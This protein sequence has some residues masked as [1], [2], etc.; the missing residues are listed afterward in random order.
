MNLAFFA[1]EKQPK[2]A[3]VVDDDP[4]ILAVYE[5]ALADLGFT[6]VLVSNAC[7]AL[8]RVSDIAPEIVILDQCMPEMTG[9]ELART[10]RS[11]CCQNTPIIMVSARQNL[12]Q[13]ALAAGATAWLEKPFD[14]S[15]LVDVVLENTRETSLS[16]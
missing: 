15:D 2:Y 9:V 16:A 5:L 14:F 1:D 12:K 3:L 7:E 10:I 4:G 8:E 6:T 11:R 13:I